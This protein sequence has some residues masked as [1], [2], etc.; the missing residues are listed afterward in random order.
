MDPVD[1][2]IYRACVWWVCPCRLCGE[3]PFV[4]KTKSKL[5]EEITEK[6]L[7]FKQSVWATVSDAGNSHVKSIH[8]AGIFLSYSKVKHL[9]PQP[10]RY[11]PVCWTW[12]PL[13]ACLP[14]SC[15][16]TPGSPWDLFQTLLFTLQWSD[17]NCSCAAFV[18][19]G[20][21][22]VPSTPCNV[23]EMMRQHLEERAS[24]MLSLACG[25]WGHRT[26]PCGWWER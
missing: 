26:K 24:K 4:S 9:P 25:V 19:Q 7:R 20:D 18:H 23:L 17:G 21:T 6:G 1:I 11:W 5:L 8:L 14:P 13:I 12:I 16:K 10:K 2:Q 15:W 3:P 22:G